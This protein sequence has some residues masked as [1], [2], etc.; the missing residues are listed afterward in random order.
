M[1]ERIIPEGIESAFIESWSGW[2]EMEVM[3]IMF[4]GAKF[5]P[6]LDLPTDKEYT[7]CLDLN[8]GVLEVYGDDE[9]EGDNGVL[10][11]RKV[12]LNILPA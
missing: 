5:K 6:G 11:S 4:Y 3:S 2:D 8:K 10:L 9:S 12:T 1:S 7:V